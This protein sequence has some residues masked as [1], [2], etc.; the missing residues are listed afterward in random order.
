MI[1]T[2]G[3]R[4]T[5]M[6]CVMM[7]FFQH[8]YYPLTNETFALYYIGH[9]NFNVFQFLTH[10]FLH[11]DV[12]HITLNL[13][14]FAL[15]GSR[16]QKLIGVGNLIIVFCGSVI[17]GGCVH[18]IYNMLKLHIYTGTAFP[19][20]LLSSDLISSFEYNLKYGM[21]SLLIY[22]QITIGA[23]GGVFGCM[24]AFMILLPNERFNIIFTPFSISAKIL[25]A[26]SLLNEMFL[27]I[28]E[29][30]PYIAHFAHVGGALS[31]LFFGYFW[32]KKLNVK[33]SA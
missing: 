32:L 7:Y 5:I 31:G 17:L 30:S 19:P 20:E 18:T 21:D 33:N 22:N 28:Y 24:I 27:I 1:Y 29:P 25:V 15:F 11:A 14:L 13:F 10:G 8:I 4:I 3:V 6:L 26:V 2:G 12:F 23:S 9:P 16:I